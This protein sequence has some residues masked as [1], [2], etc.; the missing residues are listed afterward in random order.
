M[1]LLMIE[2]VFARRNL[3]L[4]CENGERL[5]FEVTISMPRKTS[6]EE[7]C[8]ELSSENVLFRGKQAV[9]GVDEIDALDYAIQAFDTA[10][11]EAKQG[12]ICW[13]DGTSYKRIRSDTKMEWGYEPPC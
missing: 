7:Y 6:N 13:P 12:A 1:G 3:L 4:V 11:A 9:F 8:C 2:G 10:V 5:Y